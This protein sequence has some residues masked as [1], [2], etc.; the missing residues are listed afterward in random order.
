M[1]RTR[2]PCDNAVTESVIRT[3]AYEF[4]DL[5]RDRSSDGTQ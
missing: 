4:L 1:S 3:L 2:T 5:K